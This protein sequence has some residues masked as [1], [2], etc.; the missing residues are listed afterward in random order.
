MSLTAQRPRILMVAFACNPQGGGEHW[1][2]WGWAEEAS[3]FC[4]VTVLAWDRFATNINNRAG[5]TGVRPVLV[6]VPGW[7]NRIGDSST[8]GRWFRQ[9]V[10]HHRAGKAALALHYREPFQLVHQ[11]TF[12]TFRI[13]FLARDWDVPKV[14]GPIAGGETCPPGFDDWLGGSRLQE[15]LRGPMNRFA[16]NS[17]KVQKS[18]ASVDAI[19]VSNRTTL[20]FLPAGC[21]SKCAIVP[22]NTVRRDLPP[23]PVRTAKSVGPLNL[24]FVG[25]CV[26][27]RCMPLVFEALRRLPKLQCSLTVVGGGPALEGWKNFV[28]SNHLSEKVAFT[29]KIPFAEVAAHY[30]KAD[31]FVFPALRDSGG[32]GMLEAM[33][34]AL[35]VVCCDWAGPSEML[36]EN[37][38]VKISVENPEAAISGFAAAFEKLQREPAWRVSLGRAAAERARMEFSWDNKREQIEKAYGRCLGLSR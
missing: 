10:W 19:F 2:G 33:S 5:E 25:T 37:S 9:L 22:P 3:K 28:A 12:H 24:L 16:L 15:S 7:V 21:F 20:N 11:T 1:L 38:G 36:D 18:L 31:A 6:G 13:P 14:W 32:S 17:S 4:D 27:T 23:A 26:A 34:A 8:P 35:P 30:E 29:G